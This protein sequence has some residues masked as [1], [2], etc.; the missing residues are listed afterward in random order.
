MNIFN[1]TVNASS[2]K[3][4]KPNSLT[5]VT[6]PRRIRFQVAELMKI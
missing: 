1:F 4:Y 3:E 2:K 5:I 6:A